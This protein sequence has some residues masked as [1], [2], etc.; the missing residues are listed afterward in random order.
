MNLRIPLDQSF[1][2][3]PR[4][5][6]KNALTPATGPSNSDRDAQ[7]ASAGRQEIEWLPTPPPT[8][9]QSA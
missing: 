2:E 7:D 3:M 6:A 8:L 9:A 4:S 5:R 1:Q